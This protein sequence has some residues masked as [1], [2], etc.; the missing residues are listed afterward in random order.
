MCFEGLRPA[1]LA[2][3]H[4]EIR[5]ELSIGFLAPDDEPIIPVPVP[6]PFAFE[7]PPAPTPVPT[8]TTTTETSRP[9]AESTTTTT[10]DE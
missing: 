3:G 2:V 7:E 9:Y 5:L 10:R 1:L 8:I 6:L 4:A